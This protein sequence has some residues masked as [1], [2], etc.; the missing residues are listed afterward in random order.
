MAHN[1]VLIGGIG[2]VASVAAWLLCR[3]S[4]YTVAAWAAPLALAPFALGYLLV[5]LFQV[6][7]IDQP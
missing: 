4:G 5:R 7:E 6:E 1:A 3:L 2:V